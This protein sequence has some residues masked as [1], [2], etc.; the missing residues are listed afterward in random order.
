MTV[1][2]VKALLVAAVAFHLA[3]V[4]F[5]NLSDYGSNWQF[6]HHVLLMD[7]TS[8][9]NH[10][11]SRAVHATWA[12]QVFYG[13]II[14]WEA[15]TMVLCWAGAWQLI[16]ALRKPADVFSRAKNTAVAGLAASLLLWLVAFL[17]IG[18]EW[19]LMWQSKTWNG[20]GTAG[21][22]F[23]VTGIVFLAVMLPE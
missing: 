6:V 17:G 15:M 12:Q 19:F 3:L 13:V 4:V 5:N 11:M 9:D 1:R 23:A 18:G 21:R 16:R 2:L 8:P 20:Q 7:T 14:A 22:M 10:A